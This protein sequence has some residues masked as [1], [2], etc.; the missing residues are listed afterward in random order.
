LNSSKLFPNHL[1]VA[2]PY[3]A[4]P[5]DPTRQAIDCGMYHKKLPP[6]E[7]LG[8]ETAEMTYNRRVNWSRLE[9]GIECKLKRTDQ[10]PFDDRSADGEPV[11]AARK[12]A[13][14]QILS[15]AELVFKH[16]QRTSQFMVLF[17]SH[18]ARVVH[19]DRSGVYTT[20]KFCYKT[21]GALLSDFLV[22]YSR[23]QPEHRGLDTTAQRIEADSPLGLAMVKWGEDSNAE[24]HVKK[25]FKNSL[26]SSWAWW[27]LQVHVEKKHPNQ[28][29]PR[30][31]VQEFVVGKPHFQAG[32]VACRGT[33]GY[34][35][36]RLDEKGELHG[37]FVYL[38]DAWRVDHPGIEREGNILQT[39]NDNTVPFVP[40]LVC[41]GDV[42]G[43]VT[44]SQAV[45]EEA[46]KG[47]KCRM[48]KH[49]HYRVVVAE[50]GKP[51]DQFDRG[52]T[53]V[54]AVM[55]CIVAH[56]AAYKKA[57]IVHR[58]ISTGNMLLY[59]NSDGVW[60]GLLN[61][62]ELAKIVGRNSEA[63]Q[64]DRTGTWQYMS[65]NALN[66][67]SKDIVVPDEIESFFHVLLYLA[68]RFLPHNLARDSIG[69]FM[70]DYF[71]GCT[72][73]QGVYRCGGRKLDAMSRGLIDLRTYN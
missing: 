39:L 18:Y 35:A 60:V 22:R 9:M 26:D 8:S 45:W 52:Y 15:Y 27:K 48:K 59:K 1:F 2:T 61:D 3:K 5:V 55:F 63:R 41:H 56:A 62:W 19:F 7:D 6:K 66:D 70:I 49:Q 72:A 68:I 31:E 34:V 57:G 42:P 50:V 73:T 43:Q 11:A 32:G 29:L 28:P 69:R 23:L 12:K 44:R 58:D 24:D 25:L 36:V 38:K 10:D 65:A 53:L 37:P 4:D 20:H 14:G 71:D 47:K 46:N 54:K 33:R 21:E 64:P 30:I 51:L 67:P 13:L 17:L 16:Q 40:T